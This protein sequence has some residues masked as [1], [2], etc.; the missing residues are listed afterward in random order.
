TLGSSPS[1]SSSA[2]NHNLSKPPGLLARWN[3]KP[4]R[5]PK[6]PLPLHHP[7]EETKNYGQHSAASPGSDGSNPSLSP[8]N[9]CRWSTVDPSS[10]S[11]KIKRI[12]AG[13]TT[14]SNPACSNRE[15]GELR[16]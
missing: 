6:K 7:L 15:P 13:G 10:P 3:G 16:S 1:S 9:L 4:S 5:R 11:A 2:A 14:G 8:T 12:L